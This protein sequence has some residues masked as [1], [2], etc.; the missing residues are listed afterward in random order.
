ML[1]QGPI[2]TATLSE[3]A[4]PSP[5]SPTVPQHHGVVDTVFEDMDDQTFYQNIDDT[6]LTDIFLDWESLR[7]SVPEWT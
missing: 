5:A 1:Q 6:A 3:A 4:I 2:L 7:G